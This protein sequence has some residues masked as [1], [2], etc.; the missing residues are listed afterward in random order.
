VSAAERLHRALERIESAAREQRDR[1]ELTERRLVETEAKAK[2]A[3]QK[4]IDSAMRYADHMAEL[5]R[6]KHEAG[7]WAT[8][9]TLAPK[10][11]VMG[12]DVGEDERPHQDP[13]FPHGPTDAPAARG[14]RRRRDDFD[15]EDFSNNSWLD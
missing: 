9:K 15:D 10:D 7:G 3:F 1:R 6:R 5:N 8:E 11:N 12:F 4:E 2:A 13:A 14:G